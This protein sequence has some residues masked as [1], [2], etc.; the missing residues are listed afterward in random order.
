MLHAQRATTGAAAVLLAGTVAVLKST[1][2]GVEHAPPVWREVPREV[3]YE[4]REAPRTTELQGTLRSC[5]RA[6]LGE[7]VP[8]TDDQQRLTEEVREVRCSHR[9]ASREER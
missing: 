9:V 4:P 7:L 1:L 6:L 3:R 5:E 2:G 8:A